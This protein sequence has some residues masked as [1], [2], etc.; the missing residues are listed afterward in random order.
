MRSRSLAALLVAF[1]PALLDGPALA[2]GEVNL[3]RITVTAQ[4]DLLPI[5]PLATLQELCADPEG[6]EVVLVLRLG[7][8]GLTKTGRLFM[9]ANN[10]WFS[11]ENTIVRNDGNA[12]VSIAFTLLDSGSGFQCTISD[13]D[14]A[15][16][17]P[18]AGFA[19]LNSGPADDVVCIATF[20]D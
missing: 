15:G 17:D 1:G 9:L 16:A 12:T 13:A 14:A 10:D 8:L 5:T 7:T 3:A 18:A 6:C 11:S 20:T 4:T 19:L 2:A